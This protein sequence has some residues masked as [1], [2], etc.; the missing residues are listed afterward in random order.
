MVEASTRASSAPT[1]VPGIALSALVAAIGYFAAPYVGR[2]APIPAMVLAL[3]AG[4]ALN[5]LAAR[6]AMQPGMQFCVR[7]VL[8]WAVALLGLRVALSDIAALGL[9][10]GLL[11]IVAMIVTVWAG[12]LFARWGGRSA[13]FGALAG[14]K[15][16]TIDSLIQLASIATGK[17]FRT[18]GLTLEKMGLADCSRDELTKF[19]EQGALA[20]SVAG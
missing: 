14:V 1:L 5:P 10:T 9:K 16:P 3:L 4:I 20:G 8:R 18:T 6:P 17:D 19:L 15:T 13:G 2:V 7:T 12:F 11:I